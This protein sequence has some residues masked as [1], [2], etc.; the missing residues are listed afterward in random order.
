MTIPSESSVS[1]WVET[2]LGLGDKV[3]Q[4]VCVRFVDT[5]EMQAL[6]SQYRGK[7]RPTNV[8]SFPLQMDVLNDMEQDLAGLLGD[9]VV[10]A[11]VVEAQAREQNKPCEQH[12]G[13]MIVHGVLHLL[14]YDHES[15]EQAYEMEALE[16]QLLA[17]MNIP[18]PYVVGP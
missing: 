7:S 3:A 10:C 1:H 14:G 9:V 12:Y 18:N 16:I 5:E 2:T 11:P 17:A 4:S 13:H 15:E 8:L 6:N